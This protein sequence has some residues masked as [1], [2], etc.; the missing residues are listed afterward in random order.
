MEAMELSVSCPMGKMSLSMEAAKL[1]VP[2][3]MWAFVGVRKVAKLSVF[4]LSVEKGCHG[5]V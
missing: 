2:S 3:G 5:A 1:S 4:L